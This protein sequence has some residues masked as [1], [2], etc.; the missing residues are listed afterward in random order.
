VDNVLKPTFNNLDAA[1]RSFIRSMPE[2]D[3]TYAL[4]AFVA[5]AT[6]ALSIVHRCGFV[7]LNNELKQLQQEFDEFGEY[8]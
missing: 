1:W 2:M 7:N 5:G 3:N 6:A 4:L 8:I